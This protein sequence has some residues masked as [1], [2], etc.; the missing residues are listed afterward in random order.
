MRFLKAIILTLG[1]LSQICLAPPPG[2]KSLKLDTVKP[3]IKKITSYDRNNFPNYARD[4]VKEAKTQKS[5][6][7]TKALSQLEETQSNISAQ[8][9]ISKLTN[10]P[11]STHVKNQYARDAGLPVFQMQIFIKEEEG[12]L[13]I[14]K[15]FNLSNSADQKAKKMMA[16]ALQNEA[17]MTL[18]A[19]TQKIYCQVE[20]P[21]IISWGIFNSPLRGS[22]TTP[23]GY[24]EMTYLDSSTWKV[25]EKISCPRNPEALVQKIVMAHSCL[26]RRVGI[27]H[28]DLY[29]RK[30]AVTGPVEYI[31]TGNI[32]LN[33]KNN[34]IALIDYGEAVPG[35]KQINAD[36]QAALRRLPPCTYFKK[37]AGTSPKKEKRKPLEEKQNIQ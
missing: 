3:K 31:N 13:S 15:L 24:I 37:S 28:N 35:P 36:E 22:R 32:M 6:E 2:L 12:R 27:S 25:F 17:Y 4:F 21:N 18:L 29:V 7:I 19:R 34:R 1:S 30:E 5:A 14:I 9:L 11:I 26:Q 20:I 8:E 10:Q 23:F 16:Q 33:I